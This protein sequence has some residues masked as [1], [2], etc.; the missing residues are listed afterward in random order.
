MKKIIIIL[1]FSTVSGVVCAESASKVVEQGNRYYSDGMYK[2]AEQEYDKAAELKADSMVPRFNKA[3]SLYQ[4]GELDKAADLYSE[5]AA[6]S[7][8]KD[9]VAAAKYNLGNSKFRIAAE[10]MGG[11]KSDMDGAIGEYKDAVKSFRQVLDIDPGNEKAGRNIEVVKQV[12]QKLAEQKQQMEQQQKEQEKKH[13]EAKEKLEDVK[14]KQKKL[15]EENKQTQEKQEKG[16]ISEKQAQEEFKQQQQKQQE[17]NEETKQAA[18]QAQEAFGDSEE[19]KKA[20]ENVKDAMADQQKAADELGEADGKEA[21]ESQDDA[22]EKLQKAID[23]LS[24]G[25]EKDKQ[26][27]DGE[28]KEDDEKK[29]GEKDDNDKGEQ[30][31]QQDQPQN[32]EDQ[33]GDKQDGQET[34][35]QQAPDATA[36]QILKKEKQDKKNRR[37]IGIYKVPVEKDW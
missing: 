36:E 14:E 26:K 21:K 22:A 23:E 32:G 15:A 1:V 33:Q 20:A 27:K 16:E 29:N 12:I 3:T 19:T 18:G 4:L 5:V 25:D 35:P 31:D 2:E 11:E 6:R 28:K 17:L 8:D 24:K 7:K 37:A 34:E 13:Q 9:L 30:G 10:K